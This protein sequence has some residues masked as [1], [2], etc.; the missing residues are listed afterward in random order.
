M[1]C[2]TMRWPSTR[3]SVPGMGALLQVRL[4]LMSALPQLVADRFPVVNVCMS[5][6]LGA[7][8]SNVCMSDA[9]GAIE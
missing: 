6:A 4:Q 8:E 7:I 5:D 1:K 9:L 2:S 3:T